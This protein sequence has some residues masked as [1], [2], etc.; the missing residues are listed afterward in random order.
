MSYL[1]LKK[2][3]PLIVNAPPQVIGMFTDFLQR[4]PIRP[5]NR[6]TWSR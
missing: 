4:T 1:D 5:G 2:T 6:M 3:G